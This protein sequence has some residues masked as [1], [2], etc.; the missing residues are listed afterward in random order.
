MEKIN[1]ENLEP[2]KHYYIECLTYDYNFE[3]PN[4]PKIVNKTYP[5]V[6]GTFD[7][8]AE[9]EHFANGYRLAIFKNFRSIRILRII[10]LTDDIKKKII[11]ISKE[12]KKLVKIILKN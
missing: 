3:F 8:F 1:R 11:E 6:M 5:K 7:K 2:G 12:T 10:S 4:R 9:N